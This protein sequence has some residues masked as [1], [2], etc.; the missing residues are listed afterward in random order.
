M[1]MDRFIGSFEFVLS[2]G[3]AHC[4]VPIDSDGLSVI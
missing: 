2:I 1:I 3:I 4:S